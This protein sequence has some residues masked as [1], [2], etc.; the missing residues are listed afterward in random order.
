MI[1]LIIIMIIV[2]TIL[3]SQNQNERGKYK[4]KISRI[5]STNSDQFFDQYFIEPKNFYIKI[6]NTVPCVA[7]IGNVDISKIFD[8]VKTNKYGKAIEV[9]QRI[10]HDWDNDKIRFSKTLFVLENK[11]VIKSF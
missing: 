2:F 7:Y 11:I 4:R 8:L 10:Y 1:T 3:L 5:K 6:F 9:F